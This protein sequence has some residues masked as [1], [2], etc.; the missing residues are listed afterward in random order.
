MPCPLVR[1]GVARQRGAKPQAEDSDLTSVFYVVGHTFKYHS[2]WCSSRPDNPIP[3]ERF[4]PFSPRWI[5]RSLHL[6]SLHEDAN[7][8]FKANISAPL[9]TG[10]MPH[11]QFIP[12]LHEDKINRTDL[13]AYETKPPD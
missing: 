10:I 2:P 13:A 8:S 3:F 5:V 7:G 6:E 4:F 9:A 11:V 1:L 12:E